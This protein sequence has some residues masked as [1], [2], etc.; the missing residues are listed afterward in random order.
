MNG[1]GACL[2]VIY[3]RR[4][5]D[6]WIGYVVKYKMADGMGSC[7]DIPSGR[8]CFQIIHER[9]QRVTLCETI[10]IMIDKE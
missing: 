10:I 4:T 7:P 1:Y 9:I 8:V 2:E 5:C 6:C 3:R